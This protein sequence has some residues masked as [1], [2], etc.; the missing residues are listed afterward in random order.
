VSTTDIRA[1]RLSAGTR[2]RLVHGGLIGATVLYVGVLI[3][4][5][6][7]GI[8]VAALKPGLSAWRAVFADP[9]AR[10]AYLL[11][12]F[13]TVET[14]LVTTVLGVVVALVLARD[15]FPGRAAVS[16]VV[17]LPLAVSPVVVGLAAVL[18]FGLGGWF[19]PWFAARG[20][21]ILFAVP[22]MALVT[23]FISIPFVIREVAPLLQEL[24]TEEEEAARTLGASHLQTFFR[25]TI[26]NVRWGLL[27]GI[28][29]TTARA[30][31]EVGAVLI[32]SGT[33]AGQTETSTLYI[34]RA[35]DEGHDTSGYVVAL[36]LAM[37]SIVMLSGIEIFKRKQ[38]RERGA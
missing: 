23:I 11:T 36:T 12:G 2:R 1:S 21:Q 6:L 25:V 19:E 18:L 38:E 29:L 10:H 31:G 3:L 14:L 8:A 35:F 26:P 33:I 9:Y 17:D 37:V 24:G 28:A 16:A 7:I 15:R 20:I 34:L 32:V 13:I 27:Y 30:L 4:A 22:S 5:P